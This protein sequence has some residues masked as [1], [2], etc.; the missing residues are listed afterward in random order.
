VAARRGDF[1][2]VLTVRGQLAA[3]ETASIRAETRGKISFLVPEGSIVAEGDVLFSLE[4]V[5]AERELESTLLDLAVA[6]SNLAKAE[7]AERSQVKKD[8]LS[9]REKTAQ[10]EFNRLKLEQEEAELAKK[11]RQVANQILAAAELVQADL[12][13]QQARLSVDNAEI[14]LEKLREDM[15]SLRRTLAL[16]RA[17]AEAS[18]AKV[19][20]QVQERRE[21]LEKATARAP[22]AGIVVH[23]KGWNGQTLKVGD[24]VWRNTPL[25]ELPVLSVMEVH[26]DVNEV[27]IAAL[28]PGTP[29]RVRVEAF[30]D[31]RLA[32]HVTDTSALAR[33]VKDDE[34]HPTGVRVF[35]VKVAL[36]A[37]DERLRPGLSASVELV[38][39]RREDVVLVPVAAVR[40]EG[41]ARFVLE[42]GGRQRAVSVAA[43]STEEAV[44]A[45]GLEP[46]TRV[47]LHAS[48][49]E[50]EGG[51]APAAAPEV[52]PAVP[53]PPAGERAGS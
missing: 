50:P 29:A 11:R 1:E 27:D 43:E 17:S 49:D 51:P 10:L 14:E 37:Q 40:G 25:L 21:Y 33:D 46:G 32:G 22:R 6:E 24:D 41:D 16:D 12:A 26:A 18:L 35:E 9:L 52:A 13:V 2:R 15:T 48:A 31:L 38:L 3:K 30:P 8:D 23:A 39:E 42:E 4:T 53:A 20:S 44:I 47:L 36:D 34:G 45:E 5:E 28:G 7:E 19:R